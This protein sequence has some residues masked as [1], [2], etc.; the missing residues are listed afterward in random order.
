[1]FATVVTQLMARFTRLLDARKAVKMTGRLYLRGIVPIA[2]CY[3][4]SLV[5]NNMTYLYLSVAFIQMLKAAGP[6]MILLIGWVWGLENPTL[7]RMLNVGII[8]AG[9]VM[10]SYGEIG[11]RW[12]GVLFS[13]GGTAFEAMRLLSVQILLSENGQNMDPLV[14]LYYYA[15][16]CAIMNFM[17]AMAGE[18][19]NF[20]YADLDRIGSFP[21]LLSAILAFMLN[22]SSVYVVRLAPCSLFSI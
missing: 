1:M 8:V 17:I 2:L 6:P 12:I 5:C 10:A 15:P 4:A 21:L 16:V 7:R 3:T 11:F 22:V 20:D 9:V 14:S 18:L 13:V 19:P